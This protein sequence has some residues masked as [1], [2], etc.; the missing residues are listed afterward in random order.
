MHQA[1]LPFQRW[2]S[3]SCIVKHPTVTNCPTSPSNS[4][5]SC[6]EYG[7][8]FN[9]SLAYRSHHRENDHQI[10][11]SLR[12]VGYPH[13]S[14]IFHICS[15]YHLISNTS[16]LT[17]LPQ[18]NYIIHLAT[19]MLPPLLRNSLPCLDGMGKSRDCD[20]TQHLFK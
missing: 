17:L 3:C 14:V 7:V 2:N 10:Q 18:S 13:Y 19:S 4:G 1:S 12:A 20:D 8:C 11:T 15:S 9:S 6:F 5:I 16:S